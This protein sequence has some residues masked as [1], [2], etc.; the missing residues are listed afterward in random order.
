MT[1]F[2]TDY[3]ITNTLREGAIADLC[4]AIFVDMADPDDVTGTAM[5][6]FDMVVAILVP[7]VVASVEGRR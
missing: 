7:A 1:Y 3:G 2:G 4:E 6:V 5:R